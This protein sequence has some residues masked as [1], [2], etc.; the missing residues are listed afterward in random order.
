M[1]ERKERPRNISPPLLIYCLWNYMRKT[2]TLVRKREHDDLLHHLE[3][4][5]PSVG[6]LQIFMEA[7]KKK[8]QNI[9]RNF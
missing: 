1:S 5:K 3:V 9:H 8:D 4:M 7:G 2:F 6:A